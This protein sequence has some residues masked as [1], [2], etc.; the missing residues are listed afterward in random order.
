MV[1]YPGVG[2]LNPPGICGGNTVVL[3]C[4]NNSETDPPDPAGAKKGDAISK[5][6]SLS[7]LLITMT[8]WD[9][10]YEVD[11]T[12]GTDSVFSAVR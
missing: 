2:V 4:D 1:L 9:P 12:Y 10:T 6:S 7:F 5:M 8:V 3:Y 11:V